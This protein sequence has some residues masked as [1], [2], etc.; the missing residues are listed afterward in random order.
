MS[1]AT[2]AAMRR[3]LSILLRGALCVGG[4]QLLACDQMEPIDQNFDS[5]L[6]ADFRAPSQDAT[7]GT[8]IDAALDATGDAGAPA[9]P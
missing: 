1:L 5:S 3:W 4:A 7:I 2:H 9:S 6:G 8:T